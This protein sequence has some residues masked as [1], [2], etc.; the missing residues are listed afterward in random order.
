ME[1]TRFDE[2]LMAGGPDGARMETR[3]VDGGR[4]LKKV[5]CRGAHFE[6][7]RERTEGWECGPHCQVV[8]LP[9]TPSTVTEVDDLVAVGAPGT[10]ANHGPGLRC[11]PVRS[12]REN[13]IV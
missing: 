11:A 5:P 3:R 6:S 12:L 2:Q 4:M 13:G 7:C 10:Q 9:V 8:D 1:L